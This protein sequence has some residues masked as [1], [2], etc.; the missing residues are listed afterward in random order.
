MHRSLK[1]S[2]EVET[3]VYL[4]ICGQYFTWDV[5]VLVFNTDGVHAHLMGYKLDAVVGVIQSLNITQLRHTRWT[6]HAGRH[7]KWL[8]AWRQ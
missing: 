1:V 2:G 8:S 6:L 4:C 3:N 5:H 7:V